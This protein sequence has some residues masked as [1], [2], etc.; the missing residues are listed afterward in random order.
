MPN[1]KPSPISILTCFSLFILNIFPFFSR[2][3]VNLHP[4]SANIFLALKQLPYKTSILYIAAH[5]DDEN[6]RLLTYLVK[7]RHIRTGY[8]A[9]TRGEGGQNLIGKEQGETLGL[10]RTEELLAAREVDGAE[11]YFSRAIDFGFSKNPEETLRFWNRDSILS[12]MVWVIRKFQPEIIMDRFPTTGEGG[13][14]N[15]TASAILTLDAVKLAANPEAFPNQLKYCSIWQVKKVFWNTFNFGGLNTTAKDQLHFQVNGYSPLLGMTFGELAAKSRSNHKSQGFG[16]GSSKGEQYEYFKT[17]MGTASQSDFL[18]GLDS[19][20]NT[21]PGADSAYRNINLAIN[22]FS[23]ENPDR[24]IPLLVRAYQEILKWPESRLKSEKLKAITHII[25][26]CS[27]IQV[28]CTSTKGTLSFDSPL[29]IGIDLVKRRKVP[30]QLIQFNL[31]DEKIQKV[32]TSMGMDLDYLKFVHFNQEILLDPS[33]LT[34]PYQLQM[35]HSSY[36]YEI[37][38]QQWIG[39]AKKPNKLQVHLIFKILGQEFQEDYPIMVKYID[40][41]KGEYFEPVFIVPPISSEPESKILIFKNAGP[42]KIK[43]TVTNFKDSLRGKIQIVSPKGWSI[44]PKEIPVMLNSQFATKDLEFTL[45]PSGNLGNMARTDSAIIQAQLGNQ[46]FKETVHTLKYDHIPWVNY[47]EPSSIKLIQIPLITPSRSVAYLMGAGDYVPDI[48]SQIGYSAHILSDAEL[49]DQDLK[50]FNTLILGVRAFNTRNVLKFSHEVL[51]NFVKN[52]GTLIVQYN[53]NNNLVTNQIG[54][55]PFSIDRERVT[56][57]TA[58]VGFLDQSSSLLNYPNKIDAEDFKGW[59]QERA[60]YFPRLEA[61]N[62]AY[63]TLFTMHDPGENNLNT[64]VI[65]CPW[66]KGMFI[67]TG[68]VFFRELPAGNPGA[69]RLFVNF[70]NARH[71]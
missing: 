7:E 17:L 50:K 37:Q 3:Q 42:K 46:N 6:N 8:L 48:L 54:P 28:E 68:L 65:Y 69:I 57:E 22:Q 47:S 15:H 34:Q 9:L 40:P 2:A 66:G 61:N 38:N 12:D 32:G 70:L 59:V 45:T 43:L 18:E 14:G 71:D 33:F 19:T 55:Y 26:A 27:G 5:P 20:W 60:L 39:L 4:E 16:T 64:S 1:K 41:V 25:L 53:T 49:N 31:P 63:K 10:I 36:R 21:L 11:Q 62:P 13:H 52:G 30:A 44:Q 56:D 58:D 29:S 35:P 67:Y 23:F 51:M 24:I